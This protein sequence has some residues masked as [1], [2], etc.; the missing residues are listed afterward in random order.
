MAQT[1]T[2]AVPLGWSDQSCPCCFRPGAPLC[3]DFTPF[4]MALKV[5]GMRSLLK[6]H[7]LAAYLVPSGDA[8]SSEYVSEADKRREWLTGFTGSA[9]TALVTAD[10]ALVWTDGRYFVQ[11]AKQLS[12]TE[13]LLMRSHEPGVPTLEEW[14]RTHLPEGAVGADPRLISIDFADGWAAS[15]CLPLRLVTGNLVDAVWKKRPPVSSNGVLPHPLALSGERVAD[16]LARVGAK[17][18]EV[19]A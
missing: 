7:S 10:K 16:K 8:H 11:A 9:G 12:G 4:D 6:A 13:W 15:G 1:A 3:E 19:D 5:A 17:V 2:T 18:R 14:V